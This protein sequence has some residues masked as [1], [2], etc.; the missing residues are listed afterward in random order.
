MVVG[1]SKYALTIPFATFLWVAVA[2]LQLYFEVQ[3]SCKV[4]F[5][6]RTSNIIVKENVCFLSILSFIS[7]GGVA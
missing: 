5:K 7:K 6:E 2:Y 3:V 4:A 1:S